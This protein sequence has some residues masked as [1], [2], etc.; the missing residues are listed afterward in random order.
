MFGRFGLGDLKKRVMAK[1]GWPKLRPDFETEFSVPIGTRTIGYAKP[2]L[3]KVCGCKLDS[4]KKGPQRGRKVLRCPM[5]GTKG[6]VRFL[7]KDQIAT[8]QRGSTTGACAYVPIPFGSPGAPKRG[9]G[10]HPFTFKTSKGQS[11]TLRRKPRAKAARNACAFH[12]FQLK[13]RL[14]KR[15]MKP[16]QMPS[17]GDICGSG[18]W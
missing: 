15:G 18:N 14:A 9:R 3:R 2:G 5:S 1:R 11:I 16:R 13:R 4:L 17:F 10:K 6:V 8:L 12:F 7:R